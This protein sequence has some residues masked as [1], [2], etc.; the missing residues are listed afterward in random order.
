[1]STAVCIIDEDLSV[2]IFSVTDDDEVLALVPEGDDCLIGIDASLKV[3]N[4]TGMRTTE[5]MVRRMGI[6][7]LPTSKSYLKDKFG[8]SRG[9]RIVD[10][11]GFKGFRLARLEDHVGRLMFEV[12]PY[13]TVR[14]MMGRSPRYKH[15]RMAGKRNGCLDILRA[16]LDQHPELRLPEGL[17]DRIV[18]ADSSGLKSASDQLDS[19]LG[20]ISVYRHA[21]YRGQTTRMIGDEEN[22]FI[23]LCR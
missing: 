11:L 22:G 7:I 18:Q 16:I 21:I 12:F 8:G 19:L 13:A 9:E 15:G 20:A 4:E 3:Q 14:C 23:L 2:G 1:L 6:N 10:A 17:G 5:K